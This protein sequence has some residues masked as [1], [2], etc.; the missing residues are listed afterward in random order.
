MLL[1]DFGPV[2]TF[3]CISLKDTMEYW[4]S[5]YVTGRFDFFSK[6]YDDY[7]EVCELFK[8]CHIILAVWH[9]LP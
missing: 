2:H 1:L 5:F 8:Q 3:S 7:H 9:V 6:N 4:G